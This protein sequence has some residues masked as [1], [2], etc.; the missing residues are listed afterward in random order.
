[1]FTVFKNLTIVLVALMERK[2]F[3]VR[4]SMLKWTAFL[5]IVLSSVRNIPIDV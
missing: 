5:L 3:K 2:L 1:M 4:L